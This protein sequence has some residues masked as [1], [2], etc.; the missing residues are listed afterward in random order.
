MNDFTYRQISAQKLTG[1]DCGI[2]LQSPSFS[3]ILSVVLFSSQSSDLGSE[4]FFIFRILSA[5]QSDSYRWDGY[6]FPLQADQLVS[7]I[8]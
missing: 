6:K 2:S 8:D 3:L 1:H 4:D 7:V 5:S